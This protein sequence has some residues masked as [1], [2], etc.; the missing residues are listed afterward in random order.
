MEIL[1]K[2]II[3]NLGFCTSDLKKRHGLHEKTIKKRLNRMFIQHP[4]VSNKYLISAKQ[5]QLMD[6]LHAYLH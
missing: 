4:K 2:E 3:E 6:D 5:L 1:E